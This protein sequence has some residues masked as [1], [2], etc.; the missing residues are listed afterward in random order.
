M[1]VLDI[2]MVLTSCATKIMALTAIAPIFL[3]SK[4]RILRKPEKMF[5]WSFPSSPFLL[6]VLVFPKASL[7]NSATSVALSIPKSFPAKRMPDA[8]FP[9][10]L[11]GASCCWEVLAD[12]RR[13]NNKAAVLVMFWKHSEG[14]VKCMRG[15]AVRCVMCKIQLW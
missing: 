9:S 3:A 10:M 8:S 2:W 6:S 1:T 5:C 14:S 11:D 12:R 7:T 13:S 15:W 4:P